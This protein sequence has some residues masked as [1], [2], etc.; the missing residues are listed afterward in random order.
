MTQYSAA[1]DTPFAFGPPNISNNLA[2]VL[3]GAG[4]TQLHI[5]ETL[6]YAHV[7]YFF[8]GL[9]DEPYA[10]EKNILVPSVKDIEAQP[11]MKAAE[12]AD[13][14][15]A[16]IQAEGFA[17]IIVNFANADMLAHTGNYAAT[18]A[19]VQAVDAGVGRIMEAV[20]AKDGILAITADHANAE[21]LIDPITSKAESRH[22]DGPVPF[23]L[24]GKAYQDTGTLES[25]RS[26]KQIGGIL[27]DVAPTIL[28]LCGLP[29]PAEMTGLSLLPELLGQRT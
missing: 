5:A 8:N 4:M 2:E 23:Y 12:I 3:S 26:D 18:V 15:V 17:V 29:K 1:T 7:T 22:G 16:A 14:V 10:Q 13:Q 27:A 6:K 9:R 24:I 21:E 25:G 28:D 20:L 19:G 11:E